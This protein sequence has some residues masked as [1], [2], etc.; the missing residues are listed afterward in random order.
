MSY[1]RV[2]V[3]ISRTK[4]LTPEAKVLAG[5]GAAVLPK[6]PVVPLLILVFAYQV[7]EVSEFSRRSPP[8]EAVAVV[9]TLDEV[10][11]TAASDRDVRDVE[12]ARARVAVLNMDVFLCFIIL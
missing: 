2:F 5:S 6:A 8:T 9:A 7:V 4:S 1:P 10:N 11:I 12:H 3:E